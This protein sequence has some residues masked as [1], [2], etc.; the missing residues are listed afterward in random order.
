MRGGGR[1]RGRET[2]TERDRQTERDRKTE[3]DG[4]RERERERQRQAERQRQTDRDKERHTQRQRHREM[5][6]MEITAILKDDTHLLNETSESN[7]IRRPTIQKNTIIPRERGT[8]LR[9]CGQLNRPDLKEMLG[10]P[11]SDV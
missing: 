4:A 2:E 8:S 6:Q 5:Q 7:L 10:H 11:S 1:D 9:H 3:T